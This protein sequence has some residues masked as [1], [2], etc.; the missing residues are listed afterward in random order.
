MTFIQSSEPEFD[1]EDVQ[2]WS[3][4]GD[5]AARMAPVITAVTRARGGCL[6]QDLI[7]YGFTND[8]IARCWTLA[9][10]LAAIS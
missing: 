6:P 4:D 8:E 10:G 2:Q 9:R 1:I 5:I 7:A 3:A